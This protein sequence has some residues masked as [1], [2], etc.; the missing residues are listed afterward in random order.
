MHTAKVL[1]LNAL[2]SASCLLCMLA[3][4][5]CSALQ[6]ISA[7]SMSTQIGADSMVPGVDQT[8]AILVLAAVPLLPLLLLWPPP[9]A[10]LLSPS[11]VPVLA[12]SCSLPE[13]E[14]SASD[15]PEMVS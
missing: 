5:C 14:P 13:T 2:T 8:H 9:H 3:G 1:E 4:R 11:A 7:L 6:G 15:S 12:N 10:I